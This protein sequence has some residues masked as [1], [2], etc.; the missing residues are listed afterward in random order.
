[1]TQTAGLCRVMGNQEHRAPCQNFGGEVL[2]VR[3]R[4]CIQRRERFVQQDHRAVLHQAA[5]KGSA[6]THAARERRRFRIAVVAQ[7][8]AIDQLVGT[9]QVSGVTPQSR[10]QHHVFA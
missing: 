6:L 2:H 8:H 4:A 9:A 3:A 10:A 1:M 5:R 7:P